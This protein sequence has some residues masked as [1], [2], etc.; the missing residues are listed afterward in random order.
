[1][2]FNAPSSDGVMENLPMDMDNLVIP[3]AA[4]DKNGEKSEPKIK[5]L[6]LLTDVSPENKA[7]LYKEKLKQC[8]MLFDFTDQLSDFD[9]KEAKKKILQELIDSLQSTDGVPAE[10]Y[11]EVFEMLRANLFRALPPSN[12]LAS[13]ADFDPEEDEPTLEPSWPHLQLVYN[14]FL[15][16]IELPNFHVNAAK[17]FVTEPFIV[18][19]MDLFDTEDPRE[20]DYL[21]TIT[22]RLYSKFNKQRGFIRKQ[23]NNIFYRFIYETGKHNG[24]AELLE[25]TGAIINGFALPLKEEHKIFLR[26]VLIPLHKVSSLGFFHPQLAYCV[27]QFLEKDPGLTQTILLGLIRFWP[28]TD[29]AKEVMFLNEFEELLDVIEPL[30]FQKIQVALFKK[31]A[32]CVSSPHFQVAERSL[33]FWNNEYILSLMRDNNEVIIPL[34]FPMLFHTAQTHWNKTIHGLLYNAMKLLMEMNQ[35]L[36]NET[37]IK[38][39][40]MKQENM[41]TA[42]GCSESTEQ[43][44]NHNNNRFVILTGGS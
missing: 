18:R 9:D 20:R 37:T 39:Q 34:I 30:E 27:V 11:P 22:H 40:K 14:F 17:E 23:F 43:L 5:D 35:V 28:K 41:D 6:G 1:M 12:S 38:Y 3:G 42:D 8:S 21:K 2:D 13:V 36:V 7:S 33:Y 15:R 25:I 24:I 44:P 29:S 10:A 4:G 26:K 31:L 19:L 32:Q 16:L